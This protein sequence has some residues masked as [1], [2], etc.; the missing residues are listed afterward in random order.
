[1]VGVCL[2]KS[3]EYDAGAK[4]QHTVNV[5]REIVK[6][7]ADELNDDPQAIDDNGK[8]LPQNWGDGEQDIDL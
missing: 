1:M 6:C 3:S 8:A 5:P 4:A 7:R 2:M